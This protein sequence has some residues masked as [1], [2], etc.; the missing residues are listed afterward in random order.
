MAGM[1]TRQHPEH[2]PLFYVCVESAEK[3]VEEAE[4]LGATV[5]VP[6]TPVKGMGWYAVLMDPQKN[7]FGLWQEDAKAA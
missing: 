1:M 2:K 7:P 6:R 4:G 3:A 5:I